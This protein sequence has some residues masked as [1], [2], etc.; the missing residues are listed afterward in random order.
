MLDFVSVF[1]MFFMVLWT[2]KFFQ[3][4]YSTKVPPGPKPWP[5]VGNLPELIME[6]S[7]GKGD[8]L[9]RSMGKKYGPIM[10]LDVGLGNLRILIFD[11]DLMIQAF[12]K[13]SNITS[14]RPINYQLKF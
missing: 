13:N 5:L 2:W 1:L 3:S 11:T 14:S 7:S 9:L 4:S 8:Q 12:I 10:T 6:S